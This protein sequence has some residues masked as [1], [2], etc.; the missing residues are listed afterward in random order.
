MEIIRTLKDKISIKTEEDW[1]NWCKIIEGREWNEKKWEYG[2]SMRETA[3]FWLGYK[4]NLEFIRD[5]IS[6]L[7]GKDDF[8]FGIGIPEYS[9]KFDKYEG[10]N[11][12]HDFL[13]VDSSFETI[14]TVEAKS[15]EPIGKKFNEELHD[16]VK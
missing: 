14:I 13:I 9:I 16:A 6:R 8:E 10:G 1:H 11:R 15:L 2:H 12:R 5:P 4:D 3:R 7:L